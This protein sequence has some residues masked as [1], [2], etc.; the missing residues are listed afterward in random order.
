MRKFGLVDIVTNRNID[1]NTKKALLSVPSIYVC[2]SVNDFEIEKYKIK[3]RYSS[4]AFSRVYIEPELTTEGN[5]R[6]YV[7][8]ENQSSLGFW[9]SDETQR[10]NVLW[11]C[12]ETIHLSPSKLED[13]IE[14]PRETDG[15]LLIYD[16]EYDNPFLMMI[17]EDTYKQGINKIMKEIWPKTT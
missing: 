10:L 12:V 1:L 2:E 13:Y 4:I 16:K 7:H 5:I 17:M 14:N 8:L 11:P 15:A 3:E 9:L 6:E